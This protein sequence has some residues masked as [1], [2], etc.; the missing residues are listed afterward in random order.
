MTEEQEDIIKDDY[1]YLYS[2]DIDI[3]RKHVDSS[4]RY[5]NLIVPEVIVEVNEHFNEKRFM[6]YVKNL[7]SDQLT[8]VMRYQ[9]IIDND[10][11]IQKYLSRKK[12]NFDE[13]EL[14]ELMNWLSMNFNYY[15]YTFFPQPDE[16]FDVS[17]W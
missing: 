14:F 9:N 4:A 17:L 5:K 13:P 6:Y 15:N 16:E 8:M 3:V 11:D 7:P 2:T 10:K 1:M 12:Q